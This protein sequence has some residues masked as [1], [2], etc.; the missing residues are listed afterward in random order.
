MNR[1]EHILIIKSYQAYDAH[2]LPIW[3]SLNVTHQEINYKHIRCISERKYHELKTR[4][5]L[6]TGKVNRKLY[7]CIVQGPIQILG[8]YFSRTLCRKRIL[9]TKM[10]YKR[11]TVN[12]HAIH[13]IVC[14][15]WA[16]KVVHN[17]H[18]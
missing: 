6:M 5:I 14:L 18:V 11:T 17:T 7:K 3:L 8:L 10:K 16:A 13:D 12:W 4:K 15:I 2:N 1:S 9:M